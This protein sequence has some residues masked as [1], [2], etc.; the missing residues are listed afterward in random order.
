MDNPVAR[1]LTPPHNGAVVHLPGRNYPGVVVQGDTLNGLVAELRGFKHEADEDE[2]EA[3][4]EGA[5]ELLEGYLAS[6]FKACTDAGIDIP[7]KDV[8][9][10]NA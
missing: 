7:W 4:V 10:K 2:K 1:L 9:Q 3:I 5:L 6:Y 8:T